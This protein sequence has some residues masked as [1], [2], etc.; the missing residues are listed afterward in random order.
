MTPPAVA[1]AASPLN[2][3]RGARRRTGVAVRCTRSAAGAE[4]RAR[5]IAIDC[6]ALESPFTA[7]RLAA[8]AYMATLVDFSAFQSRKKFKDNASFFRIRA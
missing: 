8:N 5:G 4:R 1:A 2:T 6:D 3:R 7:V